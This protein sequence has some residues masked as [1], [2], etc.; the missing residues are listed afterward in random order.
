MPFALPGTTGFLAGAR[1]N[2]VAVRPA[3]GLSPS[4]L[5]HCD[6]PLACRLPCRVIATCP[7]LVAFHAVSLRP[8]PAVISTGG[9]DLKQGLE[10]TPAKEQRDFSLRF[11]MTEGGGIM[12]FALPG[13]TRFLAS[14]R[15]DR[16]GGIMTF[17]LP[18]TTGFFT[19]A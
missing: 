19:G 16:G 2:R 11:E 10:R 9:R 6:L 8:A 7:W 17:A 13:T 5:S 12:P 1:Y 14:L 4:V 18:G 15:N 3:P